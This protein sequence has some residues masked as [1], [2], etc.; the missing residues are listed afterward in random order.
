MAREMGETLV[1]RPLAAHEFGV[2]II[3]NPSRPGSRPPPDEH[4]TLAWIAPSF[5]A[6]EAIVHAPCE[7]PAIRRLT[8]RHWKFSTGK[9]LPSRET[10]TLA[11]RRTRS[12]IA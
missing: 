3:K 6:V 7:N 12:P 8:E 2:A 5:A 1:S 9:L 4:D 11:G 10:P